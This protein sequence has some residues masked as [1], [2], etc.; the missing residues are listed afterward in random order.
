MS[1]AEHEHHTDCLKLLATITL[2]KLPALPLSKQLMACEALASVLKTQCPREAAAA[3]G[4][5]DALRRAEACQMT[6]ADLLR[7]A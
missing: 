1:D 7:H 6:F 3:A 2:E 5:A 4:M